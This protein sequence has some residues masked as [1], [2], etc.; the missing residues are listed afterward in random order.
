MTL[1][2]ACAVLEVSPDASREEI[3]RAFR[4]AARTAHTDSPDG[5]RAAWDRVVEA[6]DVLQARPSETALVR[7][8]AREVAKVQSNGLERLERRRE[9]EA[10]TRSTLQSVTLRHTSPLLRRQRSAW[11]AGAAA[12]ALGAIATVIRTVAI[13]GT[14]NSEAAALV[15]FLTGAYLI[16]GV[17]TARGFLLR[18]QAERLGHAIEDVTAQLSRR[19]NYLQILNEIREQSWLSDEWMIGEFEQAIDEWVAATA[20]SRP[21]SLAATAQEIGSRDFC[22]L[23]IAKGLELEVI[24]ERTYED[25]GELFVVHSIRIEADSV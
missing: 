22:E 18:F 24:R 11:L 1:D 2:E 4:Q 16:A 7:D 25:E 17:L 3:S 6:R 20:T 10:A 19:A 5:D 15:G 14:G 12:G 21:S 23:L 13:N 9:H 8:I